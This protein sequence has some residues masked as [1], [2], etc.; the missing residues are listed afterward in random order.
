MLIR[1]PEGVV[2]PLHLAGP[3]TRCIAYFIDLACILTIQ[4]IIT[5]S[6]L[7][8][9]AISPSV[10]QALSI[11]LFFAI[12][13]LYFIFFE[14]IWNGKTLG[15]RICKLQVVDAEGLRLTA[16]QIIIR[17]LLRT[18]DLLPSFYL[19]G[20][21]S[22]LLTKRY[23]R[24]G[25]IAARTVVV[26]NIKAG[27]PDLSSIT[28]DK[29]NSF[30]DYPIIAARLRYNTPPELAA[31]ILK[32]LLRRNTLE[33]VARKKIYSQI[34]AQLADIAKFPQDATDGLSDEKYLKN[35]LEIIF[36]Q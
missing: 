12:N 33:P 21:I 34:V 26:R 13:I 15:K 11:I 30:K 18:V 24:L 28:P 25:D 31:I 19:T 36:K 7:I 27:S 17:N 5:Y 10:S 32:A 35:S 4:N 16:P 3:P 2:F 29:Y 14:W 1:T 6:L 8:P 22:C 20:A 9:G 23:Q